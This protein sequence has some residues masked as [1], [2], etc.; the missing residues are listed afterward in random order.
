[1]VF[2]YAGR[3]DRLEEVVP[4]E[5]GMFHDCGVPIRVEWRPIDDAGDD[6]PLYP[7]GVAAL[8]SS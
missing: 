7:D 8:L 5:G 1:V 6:V 2:A 3:V 4:R